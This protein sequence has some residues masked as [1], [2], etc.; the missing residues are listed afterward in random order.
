MTLLVMGL[1]AACGG[2]DRAP[3][4]DGGDDGG[5]VDGGGDGGGGTDLPAGTGAATIGAGGGM[6]T[7]TD[8]ELTVTVYPGGVDHDVDFTITPVTQDLSAVPLLDTDGAEMATLTPYSETAYKLGPADEMFASPVTIDGVFE[9]RPY[10]SDYRYYVLTRQES[11]DDRP[12]IIGVGDTYQS[13]VSGPVNHFST[14]RRWVADIDPDAC[15]DITYHCVS[16]GCMVRSGDKLILTTY[17]RAGQAND[18]R[19][20]V[21]A[22]PD[23]H[24]VSVMARVRRGTDVPR[25]SALILTKALVALLGCD[26][27]TKAAQ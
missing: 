5:N 12:E 27:L 2:D 17:Q 14:I 22:G 15:A 24:R 11:D 4:R 23:G 9:R 16:K 3:G 18:L 8:G 26:R 21:D 25:P 10:E 19:V 7:S 1:L 6:V 20:W 13:P